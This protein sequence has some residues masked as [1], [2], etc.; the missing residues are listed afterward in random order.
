MTTT[1]DTTALVE[2]LYRLEQQIRQAKAEVERLSEEREML[3]TSIADDLGKGGATFIHDGA[4]LAYVTDGRRSIDK[5]GIER[6][7]EALPA[8]L[9]PKEVTTVKYPS[10]ADVDKRAADLQARGL[11][12]ADLVTF[13]GARWTVQFRAAEN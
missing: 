7:A 8:S 3:A 10:V 2:D 11:D 6:L 9:L 12:P 4:T 5:A 13:S 1:T